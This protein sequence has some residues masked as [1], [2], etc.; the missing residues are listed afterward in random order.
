MP[1]KAAEGTK[2]WGFGFGF[3][4]KDLAAP[5]V[6][7]D[8]CGGGVVDVEVVDAHGSEVLDPLDEERDVDGAVQ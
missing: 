5:E 3:G 4:L 2:G 6:A 1:C 8:G 7:L